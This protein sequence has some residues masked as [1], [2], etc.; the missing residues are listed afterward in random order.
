MCTYDE[1]LHAMHAYIHLSHMYTL[2]KVFL[3]SLIFYQLIHYLKS[4]LQRGF[5][6]FQLHFYIFM[7]CYKKMYFLPNLVN[8]FLLELKLSSPSTS[9]YMWV[10]MVP[11]VKQATAG[12]DSIPPL[13]KIQLL[14]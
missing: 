14:Y 1:L 2:Q 7:R 4:P 11:A 13:R 8:F 12:V 10:L 3:C 6:K 9:D 5:H